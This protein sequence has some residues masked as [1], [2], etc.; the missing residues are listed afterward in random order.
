MGRSLRECFRTF[1]LGTR[2]LFSHRDLVWLVPGYA[3]PAYVHRYIDVALIPLLASRYL[4][5]SPQMQILSM[6][7]SLGVLLGSLLVI[8]SGCIRTPMPWMRFD[9]AS[10]LLFWILPFWYLCQESFGSVMIMV[11]FLVPVSFGYGVAQSIVGTYVI[12]I[13]MRIEPRPLQGYSTRGILAFLL[14]VETSLYTVIRFPLDTYL[15]SASDDR[16]NHERMFWA[17]SLQY[18]LVGIIAFAATF[19]PRGEDARRPIIRDDRTLQEVEMDTARTLGLQPEGQALEA[20]ESATQ[21][22]DPE[23]LE[24]GTQESAAQAQEPEAQAQGQ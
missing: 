6:G 11:A 18:T 15:D 9:A 20:E 21:T 17:I 4:N 8:C 19:V 1:A 2:V 5:D 16:D 23:A 10:F 12:E 13:V 14:C 7:P 24:P 3:V 22:E